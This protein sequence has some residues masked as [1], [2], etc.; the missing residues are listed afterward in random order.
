MSDP[1]F[2]SVA[3]GLGAQ[4]DEGLRTHMQRVFN[5]MAGGL[6]I[7]GAVAFIVA[8]TVLA[9]IIFGSPLRWLVMLA[10]LGFLFFL[11][12]MGRYSLSATRTLFWSF[13]GVM[14]LSMA[15]I[16]LVYSET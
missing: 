15:S 16:F 14:G 10:P 2:R 5:Y 8:N 13:C 12:N 7:T 11:P 1:V 3:T 4:V 6:V 9:Q